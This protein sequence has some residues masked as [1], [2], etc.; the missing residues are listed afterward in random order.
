MKI[1]SKLLK[2]LTIANTVLGV[3]CGIG[4]TCILFNM[5]EPRGYVAGSLTL[6]M[7]ILFIVLHIVCTE[8]NE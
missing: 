8:V 6:I 4:L 5:R 1:R 2:V 7:S 3:T